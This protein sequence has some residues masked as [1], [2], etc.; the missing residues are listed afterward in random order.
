MS[1]RVNPLELHGA[2]RRL[3]ARL[4]RLAAEPG[5]ARDDTQGRGRILVLP[6]MMTRDPSLAS[7]RAWDALQAEGLILGD[8][9]MFALVTQAGLAYRTGVRL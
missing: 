1:A 4:Q 2:Q 9:P 6:T 8:F 3:L 7:K 5:L